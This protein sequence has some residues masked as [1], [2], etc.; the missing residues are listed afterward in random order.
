VD[1][2]VKT[3]RGLTTERVVDAALRAA[4][5]GGVETVSLRRLAGAL[6]VTPMAIYRHV[7]NKSHLFDL[8]AERLLEQVDLAADEATT[9]QDRLR[10]LLGSY[11][12]VVAAHPSAPVLLS[13]PVASPAVPRAAEALLAIFHSAGFDAGQSARLVELISGMLL[14]PAIH[15]ATWAAAERERPQDEDRRQASMERLS[16]DAFPHL[17]SATPLMDWSPGA[18]ADRVTIELLIGGLEALAAQPNKAWPVQ[19]PSRRRG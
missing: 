4:D 18:D 17:S 8:M 2:D 3:R 9:W 6:D 10:R 11:Q 5:E 7:L 14:G 15:R 16:A 13:R 12:A 1:E 19:R